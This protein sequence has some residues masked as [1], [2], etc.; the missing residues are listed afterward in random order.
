VRLPVIGFILFAGKLLVPDGFLALKVVN[1]IG[2]QFV[3]HCLELRH[4]RPKR[5]MAGEG[6]D[7]LHQAPVLRV[8]RRQSSVEILVPGQEID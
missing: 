7:H 1:R 4:V 2:R 6:V 5:D 8:D 3:E